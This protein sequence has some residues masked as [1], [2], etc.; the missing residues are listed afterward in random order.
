MMKHLLAIIVCALLHV[1]PA[2]AQGGAL[3]QANQKYQAGDLK[4][5]RTLVDEAIKDPEL[6]RMPD[7]WVLRGFVYKDLY[8][9]A[10][11]P[12]ADI[13]RD[14]A[15]ASLYTAI[16]EDKDRKF[17]ASSRPAYWYMAKTMYNDA[18]NAL[19]A[20][21]PEPAMAYY[22]KYGEALRR[23]APDT[24]TVQADIDF[25]NALGTVYVKLFNEDR[26]QYGWYDKAVA[27]YKRVL[28]MDSANYGANYNL[29]TLYY[30]RGVY[31]IQRITPEN[32]IP[33]LQ[34]IQEASREFFTLALPYMLKAHQ[35]RPGRAETILG[36]ESIHYSLQDED[37][38]RHYRRLFEELEHDE[39]KQ[40]DH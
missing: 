27:V 33:S 22:A 8:K 31:N 21:Q 18:V 5:A 6:A 13:L 36:L 14:E 25:N 30:N 23:L 39:M 12:E 20:V 2:L 40:R 35:M 34:Q 26:Q 28:A 15:M 3:A 4:G 17:L 10:A 9:G 29:A 24:A 11:K 37:K 1:A 19:N 16:V 32:D 38:S 7:V